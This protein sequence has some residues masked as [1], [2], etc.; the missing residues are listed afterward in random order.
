MASPPPPG[1]SAKPTS[2]LQ[3]PN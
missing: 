2:I 3:F 1:G